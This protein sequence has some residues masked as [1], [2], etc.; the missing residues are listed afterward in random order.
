MCCSPLHQSIGIVYHKDKTGM[1][2]EKYT[3]VLL[4]NKMHFLNSSFNSVLLVLYV[5]EKCRRK[6]KL[7]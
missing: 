3:Y 2:I 6:E 4:T 5:F 7:N 1:I